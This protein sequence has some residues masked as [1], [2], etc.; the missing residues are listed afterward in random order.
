MI[1][2]WQS[3]QFLTYPELPDWPGPKWSYLLVPGWRELAGRSAGNCRRAM[4]DHQERLLLDMADIEPDAIRALSFADF[5]ASPEQSLR[6]ICD[7]AGVKFDQPP[8]ADLPFP[9]TR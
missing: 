6:A 9:C 2:G 1:E 3:E 5:L 4:A 7:F 8:P